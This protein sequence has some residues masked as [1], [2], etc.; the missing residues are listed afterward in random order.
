MRVSPPFQTM[1]L[2]R[3]ALFL[4]LCQAV[5]A[6]NQDHES[7]IRFI[8][9]GSLSLATGSWSLLVDLDT[10][11]LTDQVRKLRETSQN[12]DKAIK[13]VISYEEHIMSRDITP[14]N[15]SARKL[16]DELLQIWIPEFNIFGHEIEGI[17]E[18]I[19]SIRSTN[20]IRNR[21]SLIPIV[22]KGLGYLFGVATDDDIKKIGKLVKAT[23]DHQKDIIHR[24]KS[25]LTL[26]KTLSREQKKQNKVIQILGEHAQGMQDELQQM[27]KRLGALPKFIL[28]VNRLTSLSRVLHAN[29]GSYRHEVS[30]LERL[31]TNLARGSLTPNLMSSDEIKRVLQEI[32]DSLPLGWRLAIPIKD[33]MWPYYESLAVSAIPTSRGWSVFIPIPIQL[34]HPGSFQLFTGLTY[35]VMNPATKASIVTELPSKYFALSAD[36][37]QYVTFD[38][39]SLQNCLH[40]DKNYVCQGLPPSMKARLLVCGM[41]SMGIC[42]ESTLSAI[43]EF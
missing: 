20:R 26:F 43:V 7:G 4:T 19:R 18:E 28:M 5:L 23:A 30:R 31:V 34:D 1:L 38:S 37:L 6:K 39:L 3:A 27:S 25:Q 2:A 8:K 16:S 22:G 21:R 15:K 11:P 12:M 42:K 17:E 36:H 33:S 24:Q 13:T 14:T 10:H 41:H 32:E 29:L 9:S 35:P 40:F